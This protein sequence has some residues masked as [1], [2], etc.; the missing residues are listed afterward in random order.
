MNPSIF[1]IMGFSLE[2]SGYS[3]IELRNIAEYT[4]KP[5]LFRIDGISEIAVAGGEVEDSLIFILQ[6]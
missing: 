4:I 2:G 1:P 3:Q 5:F 6:S